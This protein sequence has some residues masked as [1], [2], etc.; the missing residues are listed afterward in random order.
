[1][2]LDREFNTYFIILVME[3]LK[4]IPVAELLA[5]SPHGSKIN[6]EL[7]TKQLLAIKSPRCHLISLTLS[8]LEKLKK[9]VIGP[10]S[11]SLPITSITLLSTTLMPNAQKLLVLDLLKLDFSATSKN[12]QL[13]GTERVILSHG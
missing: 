11:N 6:Q 2:Y 9:A 13:Y 7:S 5:L 8:S 12:L 4:S 3:N 1:M 10:I